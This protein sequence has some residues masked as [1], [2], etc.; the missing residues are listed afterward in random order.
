LNEPRVI[1]DEPMDEDEGYSEVTPMQ[2]EQKEKK[3]DS[4]FFE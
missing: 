2:S 3:T 4:V 1:A